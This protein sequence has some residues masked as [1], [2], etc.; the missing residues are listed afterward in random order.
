VS[1][2]KNRDDQLKSFLRRPQ[3]KRRF[4]RLLLVLGFV[5][6]CYVYVGGDYG[7]LKIWSQ[8]NQIE[9]LKREAHRLRAEQYDLSR[10]CLR[11][12]SDSLFVEKKAR[13]ELGMVRSGERVYQFV[14]PAD[15]TAK[16][17]GDAI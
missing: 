1:A 4:G 2:A 5:L 3:K 17:T 12:E 13:E 9:E 16:I 15:T 6:I 10:E 11:L 14:P 7:L 8:H